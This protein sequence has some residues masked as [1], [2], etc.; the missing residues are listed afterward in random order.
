MPRPRQFPEEVPIANLERRVANLEGIIQAG[1]W[2]DWTPSFVNI[3]VGNGTVVARYV[4]MN[5]LVSVRFQFTLGS[6]S[7]IGS[8]PTISL[9]V[10]ASS[11]GDTV[12]LN[13]LGNAEFSDNSPSAT[14]HG[15]VRLQS[16]TT[17]RPAT[18]VVVSSRIGEASLGTTEP[19]TWAVND[20]FYCSFTYEG[21]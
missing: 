16:T 8:S 20:H 21:A 7:S 13:T 3:T 19:F 15:H 14:R 4:R 5:G 18:Y 10:V 17:W 12:A 1:N 11:V 9:P 2:R 6:T